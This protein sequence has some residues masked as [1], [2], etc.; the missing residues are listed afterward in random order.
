MNSGVLFWCVVGCGSSPVGLP[1]RCSGVSSISILNQ[2]GK[3]S[4][5]ELIYLVV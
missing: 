5:L 2:M 3:K 4:R 1:T